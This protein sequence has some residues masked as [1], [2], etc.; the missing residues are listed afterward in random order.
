[1]LTANKPS[2]YQKKWS[3]FLND[4]IELTNNGKNIL[5]PQLY[6][7][8]FVN[9]KMGFISSSLFCNDIYVN[10]LVIEY[11]SKLK[12]LIVILTISIS[13][14]VSSQID[15]FKNYSIE[16]GLPSNETYEVFED[17]KGYL[18][19]ATDHGVVLYNGYE[20]KT[21][22]TVDGL[23][24]NTVFNFYEDSHGR[25][26]FFTFNSKLGYYLNGAFYNLDLN[27]NIE[28]L[29]SRNLGFISGISVS[30]E[31][32]VKILPGLNVIISFVLENNAIKPGT[33]NVKKSD[34]RRHLSADVIQLDKYK[35]GGYVN[36]S[37]Y[38]MVDLLKG[39][40]LSMLR[41]FIPTSNKEID[42]FTLE[43]GEGIT[44]INCLNEKAYVTTSLGRLIIFQYSVLNSI[45]IHNVVDLGSVTLSS[46][47][48][49]SYGG[50]WISTLDEGVFHSTNTKEENTYSSI[51]SHFEASKFAI[52]NEFI[53]GSNLNNDLFSIEKKSKKHSSLGTIRDI[54][55]ISF[56]SGE[57]TVQAFYPSLL[58]TE[59]DNQLQ[60]TNS[61]RNEIKT[62]LGVLRLEGTT[63]KYA[64]CGK[65]IVTIDQTTF[66]IPGSARLVSLKQ[67]GDTLWC[68]GL[69]GLFA[70]S[71]KNKKLLPITD[72]RLLRSRISYMEYSNNILF[73]ASRGEGLLIKRGNKVVQIT[74]ENGLISNSLTKLQ[75]DGTVIWCSS[76]EGLSRVKLISLSPLLFTIDNLSKEDGFISK[77]VNDIQ[78]F[79]DTLF[80]LFGH[81][82]YAIDRL[83]NFD[84]KTPRFYITRFSVNGKAYKE[85]ENVELTYNQNDIEVSFE[86]LYYPDPEGVRYLYSMDNGET[87]K[88]TLDR[89]ILFP[90]LSPD[91]YSILFRAQTANGSY[92]KVKVVSFII[93]PPF[94][95]TWWFI[96]TFIIVTLGLLFLIIRYV[97]RKKKAENRII[98]IELKALR[99][100]MNPH[101]SF[102]TMNSIQSFILNN[103]PDEAL[104][105]ISD[106]S[107][108]V[109]MILMHSS[110]EFVTIEQEIDALK[111]Y[112]KIEQ[113]RLNNRLTYD[114]IIESSIDLNFEKIPSMLLQP[115]VENAIWHGIS[116]KPNGGR[117]VISVLGNSEMLK[118]LVEDNGIGRAAA[119][120]L[121]KSTSEKHKSFGMAITSERL[122]LMKL[123]RKKHLAMKVIDLKD[124]NDLACGTRVELDIE[125]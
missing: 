119:Q 54:E 90:N 71:I 51:L 66:E 75:L 116:P 67:S 82:L 99:S 115:Y 26:W 73:M 2:Y 114:I 41:F 118:V 109:R 36:D 58:L 1:M 103:K 32:E 110:Q 93:H 4:R 63:D 43:K 39:G 65:S 112:L 78:F 88:R 68:A 86:S 14:N 64:Y 55:Q 27:L 104:E 10:F 125:L 12:L 96:A 48:I 85:I 20:F 111:L 37:I 61:F 121:K 7:T 62:S 123:N 38:A 106:Y 98:K 77:K 113:S 13:W 46:Y 83:Y 25:V 94:W 6:L 81:Q 8:G 53:V 15:G 59:E 57:F 17:S 42:V 74:K 69:N 22:T 28:G 97:L 92:S 24:C 120:K 89:S 3:K 76:N 35:Y 45:M 84:K 9:S 30:E 107:K 117:I 101:F 11:I 29:Y 52:G 80:A 56:N 108:L 31:N 40:E 23:P 16:N 102:N 50:K 70:V 95:K 72:H 124:E 100:Q 44:G 87:W 34:P 49:D 79:N 5:S 18:W 105:F 122:E 47:F 60:I 21:F 91:S 33:E 19:I